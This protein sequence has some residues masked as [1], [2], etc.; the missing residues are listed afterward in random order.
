VLARERGGVYPHVR[1]GQERR[2]GVPVDRN[3]AERRRESRGRMQDETLEGHPMGGTDDDDPAG[4]YGP[5]C[6]GGEGGG[7]DAG[8]EGDPRMWCDD[9]LRID[10]RGWPGCCQRRDQRAAQGFGVGRVEAAGDLRRVAGGFR[11][12]LEGV[13]RHA[14][15][16]LCA[17]RGATVRARRRRG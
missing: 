9:D 3:G 8:R 13:L 11:L 15:A 7:G 2:G 5:A 4:R 14:R 16:C 6:P 1:Q 10:A 17:S 12:A